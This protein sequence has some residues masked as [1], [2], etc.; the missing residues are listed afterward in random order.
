ME[1]PARARAF[2]LVGGLFFLVVFALPLFLDPVWW[3]E[4]F[5]WETDGR[6][7]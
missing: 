6:R 3:A 1:S 5:G 4:L 7:T 2:L